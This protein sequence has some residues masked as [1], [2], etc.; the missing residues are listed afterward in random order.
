M[1]MQQVNSGNTTAT[2]SVGSPMSIPKGLSMDAI[3]AYLTIQ[4]N[5]I[6]SQLNNFMDK[7]EKTANAQQALAALK[8]NLMNYDTSGNNCAQKEQIIK[9]MKTAYDNLPPNDPARAQLEEQFQK[10][11][12]TACLND[13]KDVGGLRSDNFS[14]ATLTQDDISKIANNPTRHDKG[15]GDN[16]MDAD[17]ELKPMQDSIASITESVGKTS[18]LDM[19]QINSLMSQR[20]MFVQM[21]SG[22]AKSYDDTGMAI[23]KN[24]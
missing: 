16:A 14:L 8:T 21:A 9:D 5:N 15:N 19:V 7:Q 20:Q 17:K 23:A 3:L 11:A 1:T 10:F 18:E 22:M 24:I 6:D 12:G 4:L 13:N 2:T